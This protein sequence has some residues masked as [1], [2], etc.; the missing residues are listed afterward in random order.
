[1]ATAL[2]LELLAGVP[3][4]SWLLCLVEDL[5]TSGRARSPAAAWREVRAEDAAWRRRMAQRRAGLYSRGL[6]QR[7][8]RTTPEGSALRNYADAVRD[9]PPGEEGPPQYGAADK[10]R[11]LDQMA[12]DNAKERAGEKRRLAEI[13]DQAAAR[14]RELAPPQVPDVSSRP[15][16]TGL[17]P[18]ARQALFGIFGRP[19]TDPSPPGLPRPDGIVLGAEASDAVRRSVLGD[20]VLGDDTQ[21]DR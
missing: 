20:N 11:L 16:E 17:C 13:A 7:G 1:M 19:P 12:A 3:L 8:S 18:E 9:N 2:G 5:T 21:P 4:L 6:G 15:P 14:A 10:M